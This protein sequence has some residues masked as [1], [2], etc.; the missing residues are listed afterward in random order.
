MVTQR[1]WLWPFCL[2]ILSCN[3]GLSS[4]IFPKPLSSFTLKLSGVGVVCVCVRCMKFATGSRQIWSEKI[5]KLN[6]LR[7]IKKKLS[8]QSSWL[9]NWK[10]GHD[11]R[12][13]S[14]SLPSTHRPAQL[15]STQ[16]VH[17]SIFTS[18]VVVTMNQ[19]RIQYT[20]PTRQMRLNWV[21]IIII[22]IIIIRIRIIRIVIIIIRSE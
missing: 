5:E 3:M 17:F 18:A 20:P 16:H 11:C 15:N 1:D 19:L 14:S 6:M 2:Y 4:F 21:I 9:Q 8:S 12:R 10:R 7:I 22:I 13:V